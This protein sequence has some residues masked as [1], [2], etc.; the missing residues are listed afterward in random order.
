MKDGQRLDLRL[1]AVKRRPRDEAGDVEEEGRPGAS[2]DA[3]D[4]SGDDVWTAWH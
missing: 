4:G 3:E 1:K 2:S